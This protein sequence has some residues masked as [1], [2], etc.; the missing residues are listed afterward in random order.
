MEIIDS[1]THWG[2][3]ITLGTHVTTEQLLP[4]AEEGGVARIVIF[5]FPST[6]IEDE[7][8]NDIVLELG[9]SNR[10]FIPYY[11]IPEDLRP[12]PVE[13]RFYGGK[14]HWVRGIQDC[15]S[16]DQVLDDPH[17]DHFLQATEAID[18]PIVFEEELAFTEAFVRKTRNLKIIIPH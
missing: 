7:R 2:P 4:Q 8:I 12:I 13:K 14:W 10:K 15:S 1:H 11:Y 18:L 5:P 9:K 16:N 3:S 6:A 17:R